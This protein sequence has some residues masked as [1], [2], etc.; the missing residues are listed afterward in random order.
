MLGSA[1]WKPWFKAGY[2][3]CSDVHLRGLL[4]PRVG[5]TD[6]P[7]H[8]VYFALTSGSGSETSDTTEAD[9]EPPVF[10][11][12]LSASLVLI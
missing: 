10:P 11:F 2:V 6:F 1:I 8:S 4:W 12:L 9:R 3:L 5:L 7:F